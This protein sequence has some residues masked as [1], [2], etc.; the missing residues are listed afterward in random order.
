VVLLL[1]FVDGVAG[2]LS[3]YLWV[4]VVD[5]SH[6]ICGWWWWALVAPFVGGGVPHRF[7]CAMVCGCS[8]SPSF[9]GEGGGLLFVFAGAHHSSWVPVGSHCHLCGFEVVDGSGICLLGD[10]ALPRPSC[11][12]GCG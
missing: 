12:G 8:L 2:C 7:L 4:V 9:D 6:A 11:C 5:P 3:H 10:V 1:L